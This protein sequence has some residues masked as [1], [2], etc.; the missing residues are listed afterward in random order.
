[1]DKEIVRKILEGDQ[2][3]NDLSQRGTLISDPNAVL[4]LS[5]NGDERDMTYGAF[6]LDYSDLDFLVHRS[7]RVTLQEQEDYYRDN[8][9]EVDV[10]QLTEG[11]VVCT[12]YEATEDGWEES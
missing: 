6:S 8:E 11:E 1:M 12:T 4:R 2:K 5:I 3:T 7:E 10:Y 9:V